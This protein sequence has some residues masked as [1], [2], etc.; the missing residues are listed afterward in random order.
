MEKNNRG[1]PSPWSARHTAIY[2]NNRKD[3]TQ[4][5]I[6]INPHEDSLFEKKIRNL[7]SEG[8]SD[9]ERIVIQEDPKILL[10]VL[11]ETYLSNWK[12]YIHDR[13]QAYEREVGKQLQA[14]PSKIEPH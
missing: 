10:I 7:C 4:N 5:V 6:V 12:A 3:S 11:V 2:Y 13:W 1:G 8:N 9:N 14:V